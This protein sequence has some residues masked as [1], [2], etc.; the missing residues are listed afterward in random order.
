VTKLTDELA[1]YKGMV[2]TQTKALENEKE[3]KKKAEAKYAE[4]IKNFHVN[5][6]MSKVKSSI[7]WAETANEFT[8]KGF[9]SDYAEKFEAVLSEDG[10]N[11]L[12]RDKKTKEFLKNES[13]SGIETFDNHFAKLAKDA[14]LVRA[15]NGTGSAP[16]TTQRTTAPTTQPMNDD[17]RRRTYNPA[18]YN[19]R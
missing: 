19:K 4:D 16:T 3:A 5:E 8:R 11:L 13:N 18:L 7:P 9:D 1:T 12:V 17:V 15:N 14:K 6:K 2:E 10:S